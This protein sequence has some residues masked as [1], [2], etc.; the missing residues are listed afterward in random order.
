ML[1]FFHTN[2][3]EILEISNGKTDLPENLQDNDATP[4][5]NTKPYPPHL[6]PEDTLV[7]SDNPLPFP[8]IEA[9]D[10]TLQARAGDLPYVRL[11]GTYYILYGLYQYWVHQNPGEHLD[12]GIAKDIKWQARW[13]KL[14]FMQT[15]R[16]DAPSGKFGKRFFG[17][18]SI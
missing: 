14:V 15:Q 9:G 10:A 18:L 12:G 7:A 6:P 3:L 13:E 17:I 1:L 8:R 5:V 11:I 2:K 4:P 16:Y